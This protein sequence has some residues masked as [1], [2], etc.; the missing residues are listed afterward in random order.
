MRDTNP[1]IS[2]STTQNNLQVPSAW[3]TAGLWG[4]F[5]TCPSSLATLSKKEEEKRKEMAVTG[6]R[7]NF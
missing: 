6:E 5:H 4:G 3:C 2:S 1:S 7:V